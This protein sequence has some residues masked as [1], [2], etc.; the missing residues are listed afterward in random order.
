MN[1]LKRFHGCLLPLAASYA[2]LMRLRARGYARHWR[3][4]WRPPRPAISVGNIGWG[5][6][7]KTPLC[8]WLLHW[9][10]Q[11][12]LTPL[13]L[14]RG[15]K[16]KPAARPYQVR[17]DSPVQ[18]AGDEPLMLAR[19]TGAP[20]LVDAKRSRSG[21]WGWEH[22][23]PDLF[24]L[25]DGFQHLAVQ[26]DLDLVLLRPED[27]HQEWNR[28]LPAGS[29]REGAQ[30]LHRASAFCIN[31]SPGQFQDLHSTII[32]RLAGLK[33]PI[34]SFHLQASGFLRVKD[35]TRRSRLPGTGYLLISGVAN[36]Q[37]IEHT[38]LQTQGQAPAVHLRFP[39]HY[40]YTRNDWRRIQ[41]RAASLGD[42]ALLCTPKDSVKLEQFDQGTLW[43][44]ALNLAFGPALFTE[45]DFPAWLDKQFAKIPV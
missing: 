15:Y 19:A 9:S 35:T 34:F 4:S 39:D 38:A 41:D 21:R 31:A 45:L 25:D 8:E 44:F 27:L 37:K 17:P 16:A 43:T 30:A 1:A 14:S 26:R 18:Q 12:N 7:G 29:W 20:I 22:L 33:K 3:R 2:G 42:P 10:L 40:A 5:G 6:S 24:V 28:V 11:Q 32:H 36:P 23:A 13:L